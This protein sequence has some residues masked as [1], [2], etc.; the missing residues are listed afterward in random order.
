[1]EF[2]CFFEDFLGPQRFALPADVSQQ[3][4]DAHR[5]VDSLMQSAAEAE[6]DPYSQTITKNLETTILYEVCWENHFVHDLRV[7]S[8][9]D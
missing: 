7:I 2:I 1:M 3:V 4:R 8:Q 6:T 5:G 9:H